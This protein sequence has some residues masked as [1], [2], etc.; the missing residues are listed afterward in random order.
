MIWKIDRESTPE[1]ALLLERHAPLLG[2]LADLI[3]EEATVKGTCTIYDAI[4]VRAAELQ[5]AEGITRDAAVSRSATEKMEELA[6]TLVEKSEAALT[7]ADALVETTSRHPELLALRYAAHDY[8]LVDA[9][10]VEKAQ[11]EAAAQPR[12]V[13]EIWNAIQEAARVAVQKSGG[14]LNLAAAVDLVCERRPD[15]MAEYRDAKDRAALR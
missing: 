1:E 12:S 6:R 7:F 2:A 15:L 4:A 9:G 3:H 11:R 10:Q 5:K 14:A 8:V 13:D